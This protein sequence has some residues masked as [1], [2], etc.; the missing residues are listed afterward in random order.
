MSS[1]TFASTFVVLVSLI[2][3]S[4][5]IPQIESEY[6]SLH[7]YALVSINESLPR[8]VVHWIRQ[9]TND[10]PFF[11]FID[12]LEIRREND[13][14]VI[15]IV[16]NPSSPV[17]KDWKM[18]DINYDGYADLEIVSYKGDILTTITSFFVFDSHS[19]TFHVAN[20]S[21]DFLNADV[22]E[23]RKT[24]VTHDDNG[25]QI[26]KIRG[27]VPILVERSTQ[28]ENESVREKLIGE[29]LIVVERTATSDIVDSTGRS[30]TQIEYQEL[31]ENELRVVKREILEG[32]ARQITNEEERTGLYRDYGIGGR[33]HLLEERTITYGREAGGK[34]Y[35]E[36]LT[37]KVVNDAWIVVGTT[38]QYTR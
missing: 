31:V 11:P 18:F 13:T 16:T 26:F 25:E 7:S 32:L 30:R 22:D 20:Y 3:P 23:D 21:D 35:S 29:T 27:G 5:G 28:S 33:F 37:R 1:R 14:S 17:I 19:R 36:M 6:D 8:Y 4:M 2:F 15:Q 10:D 38:R 24:I 34:Q 9:S 12:K